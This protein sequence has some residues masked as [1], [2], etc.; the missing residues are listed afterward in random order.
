[1]RMARFQPDRVPDARDWA[2]DTLQRLAECLE[3]AGN[4]DRPTG[5][6]AL[7]QSAPPQQSGAVG[8]PSRKEAVPQSSL[9]PAREDEEECIGVPNKPY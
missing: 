9:T 6:D 1:M 3:A 4:P 8:S 7:D 5:L 2:E